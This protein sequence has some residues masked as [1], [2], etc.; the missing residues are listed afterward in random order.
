MPVSSFRIYDTGVANKNLFTTPRHMPRIDQAQ[1]YGLLMV[2]K[3]VRFRRQDRVKH[4]C[5]VAR[6]A[7]VCDAVLCIF[8][9]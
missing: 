6:H 9:L 3:R 4:T 2:R 5:G 8:G 7:L 1:Q